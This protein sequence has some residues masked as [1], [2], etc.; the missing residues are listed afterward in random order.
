[1]IRGSC[2]GFVN[3]GGYAAHVDSFSG[4]QQKGNSGTP[5]YAVD[6][7]H[8]ILAEDLPEDRLWQTQRVFP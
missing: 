3:Q 6:P 2:S 5:T 1:M 8:G 4:G 7:L